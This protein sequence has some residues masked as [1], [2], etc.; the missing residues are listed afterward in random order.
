MFGR[1]EFVAHDFV[2][3]T[4]FGEGL[5]LEHQEAGHYSDEQGHDDRQ[6]KQHYY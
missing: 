6:S 2:L 5:G 3:E 4:D 1:F